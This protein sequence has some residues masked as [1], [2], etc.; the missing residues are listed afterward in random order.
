MEIA[1]TGPY[2]EKESQRPFHAAPPSK[3]LGS[4]P[5]NL[6]QEKS[7]GRDARL[8][9][10]FLHCGAYCSGIWLL[11]NCLGGGRDREDPVFYFLGPFPCIARW[12]SP[13]SYLTAS[14]G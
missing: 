10:G 6:E 13:A 3:T 2:K 8:G 14:S 4:G 7:G 9:I 1:A 12:P 11:R 5:K